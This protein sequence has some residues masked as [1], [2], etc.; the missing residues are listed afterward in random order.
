ELPD[1]L[2]DADKTFRRRGMIAE[3]GNLKEAARAPLPRQVSLPKV[4]CILGPI[5]GTRRVLE[6][7]VVGLAFLVPIEAGRVDRPLRHDARDRPDSRYALTELSAAHAMA[8]LLAVG[9]I[10]DCH[11]CHARELE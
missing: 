2:V 6:P 7:V 8:A 4:N 9:R 1:P 3:E 5:V 10:R 11:G